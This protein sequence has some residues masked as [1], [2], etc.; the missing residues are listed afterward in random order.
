MF[1]T[2]HEVFSDGMTPRLSYSPLTCD[3]NRQL[4]HRDHTIRLPY[5]VCYDNQYFFTG[6]IR[7]PT[8]SSLRSRDLKFNPGCFSCLPVNSLRE[9]P[10]PL[11]N[12]ESNASAQDYSKWIHR[13]SSHCEVVHDSFSNFKP[14]EPHGKMWPYY[15][16]FDVQKR[17]ATLI[18]DSPRRSQD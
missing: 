14:L 11:T 9:M 13:K 7:Q 2:F 15:T 17:M 4:D 10:N 1:Q 12:P 6:E 5:S 3:S 16:C 18:R 8:S